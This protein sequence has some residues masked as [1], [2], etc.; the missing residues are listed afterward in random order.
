MSATVTAMRKPRAAREPVWISP[1]QVCE[2]VPGM[3]VEI[4][5]ERRKKGLKPDWRKPSLK[6]VVY[7]QHE[8]DEWVESTRH[9]GRIG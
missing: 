3:T 2:R 6:T 7:E 4:L 8:V 9:V 5:A 1:E